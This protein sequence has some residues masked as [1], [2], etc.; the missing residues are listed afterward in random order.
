VAPAQEENF[1]KRK[2]LP[3][4]RKRP[5][6]KGGKFLLSFRTAEEETSDWN[7]WIGETEDAKLT[8]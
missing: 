6:V 8:G 3:Y 1:E 2:K 4:K 7:Y 5:E